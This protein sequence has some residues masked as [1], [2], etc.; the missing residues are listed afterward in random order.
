MKKTF[1]ILLCL[2]VISTTISAQHLSYGAILGGEFYEAANN[3]GHNGFI[4]SKSFSANL[5]GYCEYNFS[6]KV[7][8]KTEATFST[9]QVQYYASESNYSLSYFELSPSFKY[10]FGHEYRKG[11][12]MLLGPKIAFLTKAE[13]SGIDVSGAF[14]STNIGVQLGLGTRVLKFIDVETKLDYEVTP[15]YKLANGNQSNFIAFKVN[16]GIDIER[17]IN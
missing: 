16:L 3:N 2:V 8:I 11:F 14:E 17:L 9:K 10:D 7:G 1:S 15:F 5:G 13:S 6:E 12:Y 4:P